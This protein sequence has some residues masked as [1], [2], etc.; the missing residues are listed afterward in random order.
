MKPLLIG[1][2]ALALGGCATVHQEVT[3]SGKPEATVRAPPTAVKS[4]IVNKMT[5]DGF[6]LDNDTSYRLSFGRLGRQPIVQPTWGYRVNYLITEQDGGTRV[7]AD[8]ALVTNLGKLGESPFPSNFN[9]PTDPQEAV[10]QQ[11]R[12]IL[13]GLNTLH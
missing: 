5:N 1:L 10:Y 13:A 3:A 2:L 4:Y 8:M 6:T 7:V 11:I 12:Q 9:Q